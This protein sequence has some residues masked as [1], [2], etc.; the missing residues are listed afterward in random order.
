ML[1]FSNVPRTS[2]FT[3]NGARVREINF[4]Q[5]G[6]ERAGFRSK[7]TNEIFMK[8]KFHPHTQPNKARNECRGKNLVVSHSG[9]GR[10]RLLWRRCN[11]SRQVLLD[12][13]E[14]PGNFLKSILSQ[15]TA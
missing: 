13:E 7:D 14:K 2:I 11:L 3:W 10:I 8:R 9:I 6:T 5:Y 15:Q 1:T 12:L 4:G